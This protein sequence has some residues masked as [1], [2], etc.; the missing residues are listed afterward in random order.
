MIS[1]SRN[2][3]K[4]QMLKLIH[5]GRTLGE[6]KAIVRATAMGLDPEYLAEGDMRDLGKLEGG[7]HSIA[8]NRGSARQLA[9]IKF[10]PRKTIAKTREEA[11]AAWLTSYSRGAPLNW[12]RD[13]NLVRRGR[14]NKPRPGSSKGK[15]GRTR[16][17][18]V[19]KTLNNLEGLIATLR[20]LKKVG[21]KGDIKALQKAY[22]SVRTQV[23]ASVKT[24]PS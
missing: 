18:G 12:K 5:S 13:G 23:S 11:I 22:K 2:E 1:I 6:A 24:P 4:Y 14:P 15:I 16:V 9:K 19:K 3:A 17:S 10:Q 8:A 20:D 7:I 21:G